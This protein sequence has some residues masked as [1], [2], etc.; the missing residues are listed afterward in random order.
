M[1]DNP[2]HTCRD[3]P[4]L[5]LFLDP[6]KGGQ[7]RIIGVGP[8]EQEEGP[9]QHGPPEHIQ[10]EGESGRPPE[11]FCIKRHD[12]DPEQEAHHDPVNDV[13][14][15]A[16]LVAGTGLFIPFIQQRR[17]FPVEVQDGR[18]TEKNEPEAEDPARRPEKIPGNNEEEGRKQEDVKECGMTVEEAGKFVGDFVWNVEIGHFF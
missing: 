8:E 5:P 2:V 3:H 1:P 18:K 17:V 16:F 14:V 9:G 13:F 4:L 15:P 11:P 10:P 6:D 7:E 12:D